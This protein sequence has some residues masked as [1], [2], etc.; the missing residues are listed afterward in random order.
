MSQTASVSPTLSALAGLQP[1]DGTAASLRAAIAATVAKRA[2]LY[3]QQGTQAA[4]A[5][6]VV[7]QTDDAPTIAAAQAAL[8]ATTQNIARVEGWLAELSAEVV[9][10]EANAAVASLTAAAQQA[11]TTIAAY[12]TWRV[13][14][15][16]T[17]VAELIQGA[18]LRRS[19]YV[20][21]QG[22]N[23]TFATAGLSATDA[24]SVPAVAPPASGAASA[25]VTIPAQAAV[26]NMLDSAML[27]LA[28]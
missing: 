15:L 28:G 4:A 16:P 20:A 23:Q 12:G 24:A 22:F 3:L 7:L 27:N 19:A 10:A 18:A 8:A 26:V 9:P 25:G 13:Q 6:Q 21:Y 11:D 2:S 14:N 1:A 17:I 5:A